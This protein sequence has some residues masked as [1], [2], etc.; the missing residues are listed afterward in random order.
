MN[1]DQT[2]LNIRATIVT[3][4]QLNS[5]GVNLPD[6]QMQA[7][8]QHVEE[9]INERISEEVV[10]SLTD[11]QLAE[12]V[13]MQDSNVSAEEID[14]WIRERIPEYDEIIEDNVAIVLGE[15]VENSDAIQA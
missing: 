8:I 6:D 3:K 12:L 2:Q 1:N 10:E 7:L 9:T 13:K 5:I 14:A 4:A 11:E 15:L